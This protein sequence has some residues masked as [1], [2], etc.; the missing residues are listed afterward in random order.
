MNVQETKWINKMTKEEL[1]DLI[2]RAWYEAENI[3]LYEEFEE[4]F[5]EA[6]G[7]LLPF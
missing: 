2:L 3:G 1:V 7:F 6:G 4:I 5:E